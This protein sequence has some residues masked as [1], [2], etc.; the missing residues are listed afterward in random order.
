MLMQALPARNNWS[1]CAA[2]Y[3]HAYGV[4]LE[5][6]AAL[7]LGSGLWLELHRPPIASRSAGDPLGGA[8]LSGIN[9]MAMEHLAS[10]LHFPLIPYRQG[11]PGQA[12]L[13]CRRALSGKMTFV[14]VGDGILRLPVRAAGKPVFALVDGVSGLDVLPA[15]GEA[16]DPRGVEMSLDFGAG[17]RRSVGMEEFLACWAPVDH[18]ELDA[19]WYVALPTGLRHESA[20]RAEA[21][22][23]A[24]VRQH[25]LLSGGIPGRLTGPA[26][27]RHLRDDLAEA[28]ECGRTG[29]VLDHLVLLHRSLPADTQ[30][31]TPDLGRHAWA[32]GVEALGGGAYRDLVI[33]AEDAGDG[34]LEVA[35]LLGCGWRACP[36]ELLEMYDCL[37]DRE[38]EL[39]KAIGAAAAGGAR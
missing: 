39:L 19:E 16:L 24:L 9:P 20:G 27:L 21:L 34:W 30:M 25:A 5:A 38:H 28:T 23:G 11:E 33:A 26:A 2:T 12:R 15:V 7:V 35:A 37:I 3:G 1:Y 10:Q 17:V 29:A 32:E 6:P 18:E 8:F 4:E 14:K 13:V 22:H 31:E 36:G